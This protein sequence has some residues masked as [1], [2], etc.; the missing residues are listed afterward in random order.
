MADSTSSTQLLPSTP[1]DIDEIF[2]L[3]RLATAYQVAVKGTVVWPDFDREMVAQELAEGRQWKLLVGDA[4]ACVWAITFDDPQ[5]W[6]AK[7]ADP[8]VYIHRIATNPDFRGQSLVAAIVAWARD[9]ARQHHKKF[10]RLDTVGENH[11]LI[12]H[13]TA[14][15]FTYLGLATLTDTAG[16][17]AHYHNATVSL[18]ELPVSE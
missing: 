5:I 10:V 15:G 4:I 11:G 12:A 14:C 7:N 18:F 2:R 16:L 3:Y 8:A 9:Y 13:Y 17:P 1:A 6:G